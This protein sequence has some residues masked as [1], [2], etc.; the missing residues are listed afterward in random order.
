MNRKFLLGAIALAQLLLL[1]FASTASAI[2][3]SYRI[4]FDGSVTTDVSFA[5]S[6]P[7]NPIQTSPS[8]RDIGFNLN[9]NEGF[10]WPVFAIF[11]SV[12]VNPFLTQNLDVPVTGTVHLENAMT[13]VVNESLTF[14]GSILVDNGIGQ[15]VWSTKPQT[16][17]EG[18]TTFSP[19]DPYG[20]SFAGRTFTVGLADETFS[21]QAFHGA[22]IRFG[23]NIPVI[24]SQ[25]SSSATVPDSGSTALLLGGG[26]IA[27]ALRPSCR[28]RT[29][30]NRMPGVRLL[31]GRRIQPIPNQK[32]QSGEPILL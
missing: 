4:S 21:F 8:T 32:T 19:F 24:V 15:V 10:A 27:I 28:L 29:G 1:S 20:F 12:S 30:A 22:G 25:L 31:S 3:T 14:D 26:L 2:Q 5:S 16:I 18:P 6:A 23:A 11:T 7:V 17:T 13:H 9:D